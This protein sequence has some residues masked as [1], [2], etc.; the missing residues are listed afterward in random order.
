MKIIPYGKQEITDEDIQTVI[1][2]LKSD[3]LTQGPK[4]SE[5]E[6]KFSQ[7]IGSDYAV[8]VANGT[9]ALHLSILALGLKDGE[10]VI[11]SPVTFAATA[12][13]VLYAGGKILF[14]DINPQNYLINPQEVEKILKREKNIKGII[15]VDLAG[16]AIDLPYF[17]F[18]SEKYNVW[19]IEDSCHAPG[20]YYESENGERYKCGDGKICDLSIFSF[21]PVKHITC[22][23]GGMITTSS[24]KLYDKLLLLRTHGITRQKTENNPPASWY[25]EMKILGYN[26][27]LSDIQAA[28]GIS[29]LKRANEGLK[30]R[31]EIAAIYNTAFR[32]KP[33]IKGQSGNIPGHAYHLYIIEVDDRNGLFNYLKANLINTQVHYIP[34]HLMP[35]YKTLGWKYGDFPFAEKYYSRC[36]SLPIFP[37]LTETEQLKVIEKVNEYFE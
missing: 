12:N 36:L 14:A 28:L 5:F 15:P 26:Y 32:D 29:Q 27:R 4:V 35:Y 30:R 31:R 22:G 18:L 3:W 8:A 16:G 33:F 25:Y 37:T 23:E 1:E 10:K 9:A 34:V 20:G 19:L 2:V 21:H 6:D 13:S 11:T 24:S 7:F 17:R